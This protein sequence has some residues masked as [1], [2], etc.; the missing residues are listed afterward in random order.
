MAYTAIESMRK[1]NEARFGT[2]LGPSQ[3]ALTQH[4]N[5]NDLKSA[6]LRFLHERCEGLLFDSAIAAEEA[7]D[8]VCRGKSL[9]A[10]Q[11]PYNMQMDLNRL[12]LEKSLEAFIDS[13]VAEDAYT[14]YYCYLE[15]FLGRYG[16]S[17]RMVELLSEYESNGSSLLMKHRDH[18]SHSVYVFAL[19]LAI[20]ETNEAYR[21]KFRAF[22][23]LEASADNEAANLFLE[24]WGLTALFHDIGYPFELPFEQVLSYFEVDHQERGKGSLYLAYRSVEALTGLD[25]TAQRHFERLYGKRF[26]TTSALLAF[27]IAEKLGPVYD[28]T[29]DYLRDVL[30]RKPT[31]PNRFGYFMDHAFFSASRLYRELAEEL[32]AESLTKYHVDALSAII[33]HNSLYKFSIAFYKDPARRK[34]PLL[35]ELH[36]LAWMLMLCDELQ[37]WDR[38]AYG[39][40]SRTELHPMSVDFDFSGGAVNAVYYYDEEE[41]DKIAAFKTLYKAWEDGGEV[42]KPPR[43]KAYSD[44][45]EKEQRFTADIEKIVNT[46]DIPLHIVPDMRPADRRS[47]H[48]Y[49]SGSNFLHLYDFAVALHG[50]NMP[51]ETSAEALESKFASQSLEYQLS[52]I[53][54]AKSFS[55]YLNALGCFYTDRPVDFEMLHAFTPEQMTVVAP[56]E[57]ER[58]V[59]EH[60]AMGWTCGS[61]YETLPVDSDNEKQAR[62]AL[63]EQLRCHRLAMDGDLSSEQIREHYFSLSEEDQDKDWRPFN[64]MLKLLKK[65][66][67][68]RIYKL[69]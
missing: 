49:L 44:M 45:A 27:D 5:P 14:V 16:N 68:L 59:R 61:A 40:N 26:E 58:W 11:I 23:E 4:A 53:N 19:G 38:T 6:A 48:I 12:C 29:E 33:L 18:Y 3:P 46:D 34:A 24:F 64:S 55:R 31:E 9:S 41:A 66:D 69:S 57:H 30:D 62:R 1:M 25:E 10:G 52:G 36:P 7:K 50:R 47:K 32:G 63:R 39:R 17:K 21:R 37:C 51:P 60:Q 35:A 22:Y 13:G 54:R 42:G 20:Y 15:M 65:F 8:G 67:G 43:L 2:D 28:F 56:L